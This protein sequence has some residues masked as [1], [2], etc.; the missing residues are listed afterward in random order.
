MRYFELQNSVV[1]SFIDSAVGLISP[2]YMVRF[3][4][5]IDQQKPFYNCEAKD[6]SVVWCSYNEQM[7]R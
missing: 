3:S 2:T 1:S 6:L 4:P 7:N 5:S